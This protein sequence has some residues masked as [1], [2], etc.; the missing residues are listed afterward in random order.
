MGPVRFQP[1]GGPIYVDGSALPGDKPF[2]ARAGFSALQVTPAGRVIEGFLARVP[3]RHPQTAAVAERLA[4][5]H[6]WALTK[7]LTGGEFRVV[8]DCQ[9][10]IT[11]STSP[12]LHSG[13]KAIWAS[14]WR[15]VASD[16]SKGSNPFGAVD[17]IKAH[18]ILAPGASAATARD[19]HGNN[20][21]DRFAKQAAAANAPSGATQALA[22]AEYV[23]AVARM[24]AGAL[25]CWPSPLEQFGALV[26]ERPTAQ[27][28][29]PGTARRH[30]YR[31]TG[32]VWQCSRCMRPKRVVDAPS[33][34]S[35]C[36]GVPWRGALECDRGHCVW[37][38]LLT[39]GSNIG[40]CSNCGAF[41]GAETSA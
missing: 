25:A 8:S 26:Q 3:G 33:D 22:R 15:P 34:A 19:F 28:G 35:H 9:S 16:R 30:R 12:E 18:T 29:L 38:A 31:W 37:F 23:M 2:A 32:A 41:A 6:V 4:I 1:E 5:A 14:L 27:G 7:H 40:V 24:A 10:A 13:H 17:N 21:A 39:D 36:K 20:A 11:E